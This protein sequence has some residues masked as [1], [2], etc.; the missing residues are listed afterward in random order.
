MRRAIG[1]VMIAGSL[2]AFAV[3]FFGVSLPG[4]RARLAE[5]AD[6]GQSSITDVRGLYL[7]AAVVLAAGGSRL[8][9]D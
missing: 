3:V 8:V 6:T 2:Y 9:K 4:E 5:I 7:L 1:Y